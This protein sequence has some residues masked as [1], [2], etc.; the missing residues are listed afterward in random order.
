MTLTES[1]DLARTIAV[2]FAA[3]T[4]VYSINAWRRE[5]SGKRKYELAEEVLALFYQ[6]RDHIAFIRNPGGNSQEGK[7]R[8]PID[9]ETP[10]EAR[11]RDEAYV[12]FERYQANRE[13]FNR[14]QALRYRFR[15]IFGSIA[16]EPFLEL[17]RIVLEILT[18]ASMLGNYWAKLA[19]SS[20]ELARLRLQTIEKYEPIF[21]EMD[22][23]TDPV[24]PRIKAVIE[25]IEQI[26]RPIIQ[27]ATKVSLLAR[28][29]RRV[30]TWR[31]PS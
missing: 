26:C 27:D 15:A 22:P 24:A 30:R 2:G 5:L 16:E 17:N 20:G 13:T 10:E 23:A 14:L 31:S 9:G 7:S 19:G 8:K 1:L 6:T 3:G 11:A 12:A 29:R 4:A 18:A 25:A 21:W 28:L